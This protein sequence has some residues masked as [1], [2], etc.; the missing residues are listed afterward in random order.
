MSSHKI[1]NMPIMVPNTDYCWSNDGDGK[2]IICG[3]LNVENINP[4]CELGM[5][6]EYN[7][8]LNEMESPSTYINKS[9]ECKKF[10]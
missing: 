1:V 10:K 3:H 2:D 4:I 6:I 7:S 8:S 5:H 9:D